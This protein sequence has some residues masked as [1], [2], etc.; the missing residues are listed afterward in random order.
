MVNVLLYSKAF[1]AVHLVTLIFCQYG[2]FYHFF[3][4]SKLS[5]K[6]VF[7]WDSSIPFWVKGNKVEQKKLFTI[8]LQKTHHVFWWQI[9]FNPNAFGWDYGASRRRWTNSSSFS[10]LGKTHGWVFTKFLCLPPKDLKLRSFVEVT[11]SN[12]C[13]VNSFNV[14]RWTRVPSCA[15]WLFFSLAGRKCRFK[16]RFLQLR[17]I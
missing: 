7:L 9:I 17:L 15:C 13:H 8:T 10:S 14:S 3:S 5:V 2:R 1:K 11:G 16:P 6:D 4:F 12:C